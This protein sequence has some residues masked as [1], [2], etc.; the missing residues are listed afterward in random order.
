M[1]SRKNNLL[2]TLVDLHFGGISNLV[3]QTTPTL[4]KRF[5]VCV[6]YFGPNEQMKE[7]FENAGITLVRIPYNGGKDIFKAVIGLR[8]FIIENKIDIV[9]TNFT[10]DKL[11]VSLT[12]TLIKF[13]IVG[14]IHNSFDPNITPIKLRTWWGLFEEFF[15]NKVS[16]KV[17]GVSK[18]AIGNAQKYRNLKN[19][20]LSTVYSGITG[21]TNN[22]F[23]KPKNEKI[24]FVTACRFVEIKGLDRL[25]DRFNDVNNTHIN[26]E[27]WLIGNGELNNSL[28]KK[29]KILGLEDKIIF[30]G[31]QKNLLSFYE[32]A[33]FY[34]NS[35]YNE[36]LGISIIEAMSVGLPILGSKVGGVPEVVQDEYNGY[37]LDFNDE[38]DSVRII[39]GAIDLDPKKY[40]KI[41]VN[42]LKSF[43][44][45]F[46]IENYV[47]R[48]TFEYNELLPL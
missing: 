31:Y 6:I 8:R 19:H 13:R 35:S 4:G 9:S 30:K 17:I 45:K 14:N 42:S 40:N 7:R 36:A 29:V 41:A 5:N 39:S 23:I 48:I 3:L 16:D 47:D 10:P 15:H 21:L 1:N 18:S 2:I 38:V 25:I 20:N 22:I 37:L 11:I 32:L 27:L 26:W 43:Q 46:S 28:K 44:K 34:I 33:D 24:I 12:R